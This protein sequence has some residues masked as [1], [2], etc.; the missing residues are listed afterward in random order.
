MS[1]LLT[2]RQKDVL[3]YLKYFL[4]RRGYAPSLEEIGRG[5]R[6]RSLATVHKHL[7]SLET[8]GYLRRNPGQYRSLE[9]TPLRRGPE[10]NGAGAQ[11]VLAGRIAAGQPLEAIPRQELISLAAITRG[12]DCFVLEVRGDSMV[13]AHILDGDYIVVEPVAKARNGDIVVAL[14]DAEEA[15]LKTWYREEDGTIRLQPANPRLQ[16]IRLEPGRV[17]VQGRVRGVL[18]RYR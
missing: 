12:R 4:R 5:L 14:I 16:P 7:R 10:E 13:D 9:L 2:P 6:L 15:T 1:N 3:D 8:K 18:R 17:Q 11:L